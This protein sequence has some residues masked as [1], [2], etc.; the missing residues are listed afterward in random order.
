M[1]R[2]WLLLLVCP[3]AW[4]QTKSFEAPTQKAKLGEIHYSSRIG[5]TVGETGKKFAVVVAPQSEQLVR[6]SVCVSADGNAGVVKGFRFE[7]QNKAGKRQSVTCGDITG[8]WLPTYTVSGKQQLTG[9]SGSC[10]WFIDSIRFHFDDGSQTPLY[11]SQTGGDTD[12]ALILSRKNG[13]LKGRWM[14]F[15]GTATD[16]IESLGLVFF[17]IE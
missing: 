9:I 15:W 11:G 17:P 10:G 5:G 8:K 6:I 13:K 16:N 4:A 3:V 1:F 14:G 2:Y 12:Y 7:T